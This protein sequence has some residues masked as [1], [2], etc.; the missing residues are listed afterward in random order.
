MLCLI[1]H[2]ERI[3]SWLFSQKFCFSRLLNKFLFCIL[4][5]QKMFALERHTSLI[6]MQIIL[7]FQLL[8]VF[9]LPVIVLVLSFLLQRASFD[10]LGYKTKQEILD[11]CIYSIFEHSKFRIIL[12]W[13]EKVLVKRSFW[14]KGPPRSVRVAEWSDLSGWF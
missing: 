10:I 9:Y 13:T 2:V 7:L 8:L 14:P 11:N 4:T 3:T 6:W 1:L 12:I 5:I